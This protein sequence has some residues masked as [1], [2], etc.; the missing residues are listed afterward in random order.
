HAVDFIINT[1]R[2][3]PKKSITLCPLGPLT[4][5]GTALQKAPDIIDNI[6]Q[7]VLM[8]GAYFEVGNITPAAEFN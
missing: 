5:I 1:L 4:N 7:I 2:E 8:G 6:K 3:A